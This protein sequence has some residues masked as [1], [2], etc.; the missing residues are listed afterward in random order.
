LRHVSAWFAR[1]LDEEFRAQAVT[2]TDIRDYRSYLMTVEGRKPATVNRRLAALR[3]FFGWAR[4]L[5][6]I[7]E[8][9][10]D[11]VKGV[12]SSP[13]APKALE[14]REL[15]RLVRAVE[16]EGKKRDLAVVL[17]LRHTGLRVSELCALT[18]SDITLGERGGN[19]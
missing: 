13:R 12:A 18:L 19:V 8:D 11:A 2:P 7:K 6:S 17:V 1:T 4:G 10:T 9:P 15:D 14:K 16:R 5:S 3:R